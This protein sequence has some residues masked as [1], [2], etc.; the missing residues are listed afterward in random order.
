M[1]KRVIISCFTT[2]VTVAVKAK[3]GVLGNRFLI[4][5]KFSYSFLNYLP[6]VETQ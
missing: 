4:D 6:Q 2:S 5:D 1:P 3:I